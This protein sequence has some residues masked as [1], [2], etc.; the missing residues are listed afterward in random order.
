[1][2]L[3][4]TEGIAERFPDTAKVNVKRIRNFPHTARG[5]GKR[6]VKRGCFC[7]RYGLRRHIL[8]LDTHSVLI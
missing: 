3:E 6:F 1:V 4:C 8:T 5:A 2:H 7:C